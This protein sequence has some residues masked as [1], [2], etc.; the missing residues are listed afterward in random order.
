M[1]GTYAAI[2]A[3]VSQV[4]VLLERYGVRLRL[5]GGGGGL[6]ILEDDAGRLSFKL[7]GDLFDSTPPSGSEI[8]IRERFDLIGR[9]TYFR[10]AYEY[11]LLD[12]TRDFRR[13]FHLHHPEWFRREFMVVVHEHCEHPIGYA[14]CRHYEG[15][16][17]RDAYAG[18]SILM[19]VWMGD[20]PECSDLRC[21]G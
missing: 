9:D 11:E 13:S 4:A 18:V 5:P 10:S 20:T 2:E 15:S 16:P 7:A 3:Y 6:E 14:P 12:R 21:L 8:V 1:R 19:E 17:I